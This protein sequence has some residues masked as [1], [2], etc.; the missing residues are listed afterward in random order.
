[1]YFLLGF[2]MAFFYSSPGHIGLLWQCCESTTLN[3]LRE[4][5]LAS[6][7]FLIVE[8]FLSIVKCHFWWSTFNRGTFRFGFE[9][10]SGKKIV[11][12]WPRRSVNVNGT[13]F[14]SWT[15][16]GTH[17]TRIKIARSVS[18]QGLLLHSFN[19]WTRT[20]LVQDHRWEASFAR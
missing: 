4:W 8:H 11:C 5:R 17:V 20:E 1:M 18:Y 2:L 9:P 10:A 12:R 14:L 13:R 19:D 6:G 3:W 15:L 7:W 16:L